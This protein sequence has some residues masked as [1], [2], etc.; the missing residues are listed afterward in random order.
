MPFQY[1]S[2]RAFESRT[3]PGVRI[4]LKKWSDQRRTELYSITAEARKRQREIIMQGAALNERRAPVLEDDGSKRINIY[5]GEVVKEFTN[6]ID[7]T[8][9][10]LWVNDLEEFRHRELCPVYVRWG[11]A[12]IEGLVIDGQ[13]ATVDTLLSDGPRDLADEIFAE[14]EGR[15]EL[16]AVETKNSESPTISSAADGTAMTTTAAIAAEPEAE[17]Q[18][19]TV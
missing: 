10:N 11:V 16:S 14:L 19:A 8:E 3:C 5:S 17:P 4:T 13:D 6:E 1:E 9:F 15:V 18:P 12:K 2:T 7:R